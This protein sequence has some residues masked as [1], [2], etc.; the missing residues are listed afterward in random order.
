[1]D[2]TNRPL[3]NNVLR[4]SK[5]QHLVFIDL[6]LKPQ[7]NFHWSQVDILSFMQILVLMK[8]TINEFG[9]NHIGQIFVRFLTH[10]LNFKN[11]NI[12]QGHV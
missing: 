6:S 5:V 8:I 11:F 7:T 1:M 4:I 9:W 10:G 3:K 2:W 12:R